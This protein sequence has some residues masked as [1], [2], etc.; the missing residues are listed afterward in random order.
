ME[1]KSD[2][3][4]AGDQYYKLVA[5]FVPSCKNSDTIVIAPKVEYPGEEWDPFSHF[6]EVQV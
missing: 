6:E 2:L 5:D 3:Q 1:K 4:K